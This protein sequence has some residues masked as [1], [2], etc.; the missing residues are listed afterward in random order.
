MKTDLTDSHQIRIFIVLA[1]STVLTSITIPHSVI[2]LGG[3]SGCT[4]QTLNQLI[5]VSA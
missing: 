4:G 1:G 5:L 3:F 2:Y